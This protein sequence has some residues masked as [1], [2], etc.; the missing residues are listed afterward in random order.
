M[1][2][3]VNNNGALLARIG[4]DLPDR[5][6]K[7]PRNDID[8]ELL[9]TIEFK[10]LDCREYPQVGNTAAGDDTLFDSR[11]CGVEGVFDAGLLLLHLYLGS[12]ANVDDGNSADELGQPLLK[13]LLVVV[14]GARIDLG[15]DLLY[16]ALDV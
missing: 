2:Y 8:T 16:A 1:L 6:F 10:L 12:R 15:P 3:L 9:V 14:G 5:L 4:N 7:G 13:L 11:P